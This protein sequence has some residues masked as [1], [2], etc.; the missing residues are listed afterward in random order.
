MRKKLKIPKIALRTPANQKKLQFFQKVTKKLQ[1]TNPHIIM[2]LVYEIR[3]AAHV[4]HV[5]IPISTVPAHEP[6][7]R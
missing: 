1:N 2:K 4:S 6:D 5:L 3:D 7:S